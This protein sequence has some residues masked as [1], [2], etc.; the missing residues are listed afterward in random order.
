MKAREAVCYLNGDFVPE[1]EAK[2]SILDRGFNAG[3]GVY[4]V[5][6]TFGHRPF[7]LRDHVSRL[8]RSMRYTRIDC[9]MPVDEM[10]RLS[11][12]VFERNRHLLGHEDDVVIWQVVT[13]G[14]QHSAFTQKPNG[15]ATV[16]IWCM[17]VQFDGFA[18]DYIEGAILVTPSTRRVPSECLEAKAKITNKM[19][20]HVALAEARSVDPRASALMLDTHGN[21]TET[22]RANFFFVSGGKLFTPGDKNILGGVTRAAI[23]EM[24]GRLGI[25]VTEGDYTPYDVYNADEAFTAGTS[26]TITPIKSLDRIEIGAGLPGPITLK[27]LNAWNEMVGMDIV[28]QA[29]AHLSDPDK[30]ALLGKWAQL[31][32]NGHGSGQS[33]K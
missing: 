28:G 24:A 20:H 5:T 26:I 4:D 9:G 6:R 23:M 1:S 12:E 15:K 16:A 21:I 11:L 7:R 33:Q 8:Y 22:H 17:P 29:L 27:L 30:Q 18:R 10:E 25:P 31:R 2:V 19:N 3:D 14:I 13:T 32:R